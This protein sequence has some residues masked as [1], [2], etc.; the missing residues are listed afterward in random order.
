MCDK[1]KEKED[2]LDERIKKK[3]VVRDGKRKRVKRSTKAGYKVVDGKESRMSSKEK[4]NRS[5]SQKKGAR[6][7][8][9]GMASANRKR[10]IS[11]R[12]RPNKK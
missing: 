11:N 2:V 9:V 10:K 1:S 3:V 7:R 4:R 12:K 6:K 8:K 5:K